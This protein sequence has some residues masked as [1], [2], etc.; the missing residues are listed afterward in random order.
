MVSRKNCIRQTLKSNPHFFCFVLSVTIT[1]MARPL[2]KEANHVDFSEPVLF[3]PDLLL[4]TAEIKANFVEEEASIHALSFP[5]EKTGNVFL[6]RFF[7]IVLSSFI[8]LF[9]FPVLLP[10]IAL[11]IRL[12]TKGPVFF[13]QK[14]NKKDGK[15]FTCIKFRTMVV[16]EEA[17]LLPASENDKRITKTGAF[18]RKTHLDELPQLFNVWLGDMSIIGPRPHML[19]DNKLFE[20]MVPHYQLRHKI[21]PGITGLA[22]VSG[23]AGPVGDAANMKE[24]VDKDIYYIRHWSPALDTKIALRTIFKMIGIKSGQV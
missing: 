2:L 14:R 7:D 8:I 12:N 5:L 17:D 23:H 1:S 22:Q 24:R 11:C 10:L 19:V 20:R 15:V 21:K 4:P 9:F 13:L 18:L 6:K 3:H 16:N